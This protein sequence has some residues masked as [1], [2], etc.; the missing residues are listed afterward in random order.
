VYDV[1][2]NTCQ[3]LHHV[4]AELGELTALLGLDLSG[5]QLTSVPAE[6]GRF[7][8]LKGFDISG[9]QLTSVPAALGG[10]TALLQGT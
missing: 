4:P 3:A 2:G 5:N 9:N 8:A 7:T 1:A 6:L 10:L